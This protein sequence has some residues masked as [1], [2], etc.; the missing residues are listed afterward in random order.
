MLLLL[1]L[2]LAALAAAVGATIPERELEAS[3]AAH[4]AAGEHEAAQALR[5]YQQLL[6]H[7]SLPPPPPL[8]PRRTLAELQPPRSSP[9]RKYLFLNDSSVLAASAFASL[10]FNPPERLG[11]VVHADRPWE[12]AYIYSGGA[13][14]QV[15]GMYHLYYG[16]NAFLPDPINATLPPVVLDMMCL[17][18]ST[19]GV[20]FIKP[21]L[22]IAPFNGSTA[23]NI[24]LPLGGETCA[25]SA[26]ATPA[27]PGINCSR[28]ASPFYDPRPGVPASQRYKAGEIAALGGKGM[29]WAS[30][31]GIHFSPT[32]IDMG[33]Y[34]A[35]WDFG[36]ILWDDDAAP[37]CGKGWPKG[38][39]G[40]SNNDTGRWISWCRS[41]DTGNS[42]LPDHP[43]V[44]GDLA[45]MRAVFVQQS[46]DLNSTSCATKSGG[47]IGSHLVL[48]RRLACL[49]RR[50]IA[51]AAASYYSCSQRYYLGSA[52]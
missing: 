30:G 22:G 32:P 23:N 16:C 8:P 44:C 28:A 21:S 45:A 1:W 50:V 10:R 40:S 39:Q 46:V 5:H 48:V 35:M 49:I 4:Q 33:P 38:Q 42:Q 24:V 13:I 25:V 43:K 18:T 19:D 2:L 27:G 9:F 7:A 15:G 3:I 37:N 11:A 34:S 26:S 47:A 51:H 6:A 29:L 14:L 41:D 31:D 20:N 17:A 36:A 52:D 12:S